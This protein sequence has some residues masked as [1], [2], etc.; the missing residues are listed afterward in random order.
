MCVAMYWLFVFISA[1]FQLALCS[2]M[3]PW[4]DIH[5]LRSGFFE[6]ATPLIGTAAQYT[7]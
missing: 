3:T 4:S 2:L 6:Y 1:A 7:M 5:Y